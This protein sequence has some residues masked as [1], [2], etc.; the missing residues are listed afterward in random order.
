MKKHSIL[1]PKFYSKTITLSSL[2]SYSVSIRREDL[3]RGTSSVN[4][5]ELLRDYG[6]FLP[7]IIDSEHQTIVAGTAIYNKIL[8]S[9]R[10][11]TVAVIDVAL[12]TEMPMAC[13][14][15]RV[16]KDIYDYLMNNENPPNLI[17]HPSFGNNACWPIFLPYPLLGGTDLTRSRIINA[18]TLTVEF[19]HDC[20]DLT[21]DC[22]FVKELYVKAQIPDPGNPQISVPLR[23]ILG[24]NVNAPLLGDSDLTIKGKMFWGKSDLLFLETQKLLS[25]LVPNRAQTH[26]VEDSKPLTDYALEAYLAMANDHVK[27]QASGK[28]VPTQ[29]SPAPIVHNHTKP[30]K[31]SLEQKT[32]VVEY[33]MGELLLPQSL[34]QKVTEVVLTIEISRFYDNTKNGQFLDLLKQ[35]CVEAC[36]ILVSRKKRNFRINAGGKSEK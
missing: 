28:S 21:P 4:I 36:S 30:I 34:Y 32:E 16:L 17:N 8:E 2:A 13:F 24:S 31:L 20:A 14:G 3:F 35:A 22:S 5:T 6:Q 23:P 27:R 18:N 33:C 1:L 25:E 11:N 9:R 29:P 7:V 10:F 19:H 26:L 12:D 15:H